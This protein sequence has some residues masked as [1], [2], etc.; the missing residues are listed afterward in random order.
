MRKMCQILELNRSTVYY[1]KKGEREKNIEA[2]KTMDQY[3]QDHPTAG[4]RTM[5]MALRDNGL[6]LNQKCIARLMK[7]MGIEA[8]YPKKS[9]SVQGEK[10]YLYPYLLRGREI[11]RANEVWSTDISY[12]PMQHGFMY[13]SAIIDVYSRKILSWELSN[14]LEKGVCMRTLERAIEKYGIPEIVNSDQGSQYSSE[15]WISTL[16][17]KGIKVSMDSRGRAKDNIWIERFWRTIK[18]EY[19]YLNP[20][21]DGLELYRGIERF[22]QYYNEKRHHQ[23][24]DMEIPDERYNKSYKLI[25]NDAFV[26]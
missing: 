12:I 10:N 23:G 2:M 21:R 16:Q 8:I 9:L 20:S 22:M 15:Q 14:S 13:L 1:R 19:V 26:A 3:Y 11:T 24:I 4:R 17:G 7:K 5:D 25:K 18:R 6:S